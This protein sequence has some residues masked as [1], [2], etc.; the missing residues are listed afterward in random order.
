MSKSTEPNLKFALSAY[1]KRHHAEICRHWFDDI[2]PGEVAG[3][4]LKL[5]VHDQIQLRYLQRSCSE[6]FTEAAQSVTGRLLAIQFVGSEDQVPGKV[7]EAPLLDSVARAQEATLPP[8]EQTLL[9]PDY[10]FESFVVGPCNRLAHAA[11]LA[12]G[13]RPGRTY[14]P[15]FVHGGLGLGKTH[16]LQAICQRLLRQR[17]STSLCYIS[18]ASFADHFHDAVRAGTVTEFRGRFRS[19]DV[20]VVDDIHFLSKRDQSQEEFFHT[21]NALYQAG[22]QLVLSSD[23][24]PSEI[25]DL[26]NRLVSRF[27][28]GLVV[29]MERP[30]FETRVNIVRTKANLHGM[31]MDDALA[32]FIAT[33][34]EGNVRELEGALMKIRLLSSSTGRPVAMDLVRE[35]LRDHVVTGV[36]EGQHTIQDITEA[37]VQFFGVRLTDLL[38][39][40]RHKSIALPRQVS[41][42]LARR[43]TRLSL[44]EIGGYFGG[45]DHSTVLHAIR[46]VEFKRTADA[47]LSGGIALIERGLGVDEPATTAG[48]A[49]AQQLGRVG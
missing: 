44:E 14:N 32:S 45:R 38:G 26:E 35:S 12:V 5:V 41:M 18:C 37:V 22:K 39:K 15:F 23:A 10:T 33:R 6:Q 13:D 48:D 36:S 17:A 49:P 11:A 21:F 29:R 34:V 19:V 25:P 3:G 9:S 7:R 47:H 27:N 20:L 40:R 8:I 30:C 28:S 43:L 4:V 24:A 1:L 16:L 31:S 42:Y 2:E 46:T